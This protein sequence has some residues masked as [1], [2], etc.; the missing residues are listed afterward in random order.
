MQPRIADPVQLDPPAGAV[1]A[2]VLLPDY[3][4]DGLGDHIQTI[5]AALDECTTPIPAGSF[6]LGV[7]VNFARTRLAAFLRSAPVTAFVTELVGADGPSL[8]HSFLTHEFGDAAATV[9]RLARV[10]AGGMARLDTATIAQALTRGRTTYF[11]VT[12]TDPNEPDTGHQ[13]ELEGYDGPRL[14]TAQQQ[15]LA[16]LSELVVHGSERDMR[17]AVLRAECARGRGDLAGALAT[18]EALLGM[19]GLRAERRRFVAIQAAYVRLALADRAYRS[20]CRVD[21]TAR[22]DV[23]RRYDEA[24]AVLAQHDVGRADPDRVEIEARAARAKNQLAA[25]TPE[26]LALTRPAR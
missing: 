12:S 13:A 19:I 2:F 11:R 17:L 18:Y 1:E 6:G 9:E 21:A 10:D 7:D 4:P 8:A 25:S 16:R 26:V 15:G 24:V 20:V 3:L 23:A 5:V 22:A 14:S